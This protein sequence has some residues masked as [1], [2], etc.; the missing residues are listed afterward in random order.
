MKMRTGF[1]MTVYKGAG[2]F[3]SYSICCVAKNPKSNFL[4]CIK[5]ENQISQTLSRSLSQT[6]TH[7]PNKSRTEN[8]KNT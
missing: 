8:G 5:L 6:H 1:I 4:S 2:L 7:K 3:L